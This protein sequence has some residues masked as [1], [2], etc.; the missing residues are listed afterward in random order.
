MQTLYLIRNQEP[1]CM[2]G[3]LGGGV[4]NDKKVNDHDKT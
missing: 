3:Q 1:I 2:D 4:L